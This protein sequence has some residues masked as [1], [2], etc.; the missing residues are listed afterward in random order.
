MAKATW[1]WSCA[2]WEN[3]RRS[4]F[5]SDNGKYSIVFNGEIYNFIEIRSELKKAGY[6]F[7][8]H[9]DTEV[10]LNLYLKEG[11][12]MLNTIRGM[13]AFAIWDNENQTLFI[14]RDPFG[15]KP[16]YY[17]IN[18][19]YFVFASQV[20]ALLMAPFINK[21]KSAAGTVGFFL[22]GSVPEPFT[23]YE[24]IKV[25]PAGSYLLM[26]NGLCTIYNYFTPI[27]RFL[28]LKSKYKEGDVVPDINDLINNTIHRHLISDVEVGVFLSSG[29][30]STT[31][32]GV[33]SE[34]NSNIKTFT[35]GFDEYR[36]TSFDETKLAEL[37]SKYY[38][39]DH[40]T[41]W[42][43]KN[44]LVNDYDRIFSQMDQPTI[45][46]I[47]T[48]FVSKITAL[49]GIKVALSGLGGDELFGGYSD[50][51]II[52]KIVKLGKYFSNTYLQN[53]VSLMFEQSIFLHKNPKLNQLF[54]YNQ[55]YSKAYVLKKLLFMP[56][57]LFDILDNDL[58]IKGLDE[59]SFNYLGDNIVKHVGENQLAISLLE[60]EFYMKNQLLRDSDWASMA[61]SLE[62]RVP[63]VDIHVFDAVILN[64]LNGRQLTKLDLP[65]SIKIR[66]L[67]DY[68]L[69][70]KKTGFSIPVKDWILDAYSSKEKGLRSW[71]KLVYNEYIKRNN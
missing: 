11:T 18:D 47:N 43:S 38:G 65:N 48:Y 37:V 31:I 42:L 35:L 66:S 7:R 29:I 8:T 28:E 20:R 53:L 61:H 58:V 23:I 45:N 34:V 25:L 40:K 24:D 17:S 54:N 63:L 67:P 16:L 50:F 26:N 22:F 4:P 71:S 68:I 27:N 14:A 10:L 49:N 55:S 15:I 9:S 6:S 52:P 36:G 5:I 62:I 56:D 57:E 32:L 2:K 69:N 30:D 46:G 39:S 21:N 13:F 64:Y 3:W 70:R 59:L 1:C 19:D 51:K 33:C 44:D 41:V 12:K 60:I